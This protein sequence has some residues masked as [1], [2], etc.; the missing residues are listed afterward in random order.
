MLPIYRKTMADCLLPIGGV[1]GAILTVNGNRIFVLDRWGR[2]VR[3]LDME[4]KPV[5]KLT[6]K[7]A[8]DL[9]LTCNHGTDPIAESEV[10]NHGPNHEGP[11]GLG[12]TVSETGVKSA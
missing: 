7:T 1:R 5:G 10:P 3:M 4:K 8:L 2:R 12:F 11:Q 9:Q 6:T